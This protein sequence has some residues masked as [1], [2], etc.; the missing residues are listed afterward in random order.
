MVEV[1][2]TVK[3]NAIHTLTQERLLATRWKWAFLLTLSIFPVSLWYL[4]IRQKV[5]SFS[6]YHP[7]LGTIKNRRAQRSHQLHKAEG[8]AS[9]CTF[10]AE[11]PAHPS[12]GSLL[13]GCWGRVSLAVPHPS[14]P[15]SACAKAAKPKA[16]HDCPGD[17]Q[18]P[19]QRAFPWE[20]KLG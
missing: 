6:P 17:M 18:Q 16:R 9:S 11:F 19:Q 15:S 4:E 14:P 3:R 13:P 2:N 7:T 10:K 5:T 12:Q 20:H 1:S 8:Y